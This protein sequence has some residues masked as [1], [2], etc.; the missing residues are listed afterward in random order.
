M[1]NNGIYYTDSNATAQSLINKP[2]FEVG[3]TSSGA[4]CMRVT[5]CGEMIYQ[6]LYS[7]WGKIAI[8]VKQ[9]SG[10]WGTWILVR[11]A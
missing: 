2:V 9:A 7:Y 10:L 8:R 3:Q 6:F 4:F 5:I 11:D 1:T